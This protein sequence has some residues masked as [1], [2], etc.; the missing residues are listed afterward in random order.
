MMNTVTRMSRRDFFAK[1]GKGSLAV[2]FSLSPTAAA[3]FSGAARAA[4][5]TSELSVL[6]GIAPDNDA[7]ITI[8]FQGTVTLFSG[9]V[10]LGTGVE[11]AFTQIVA[12]ELYVSIAAVQ[13]I[14]GDTEITPDQG[15]TAGSKSVQVQGPLVRRAAATA[16][17]QLLQ[18]AATYLG[19]PTSQLVASNGSIGI[20]PSMKRATSY[21][22]LFSGQQLDI[23]TNPSAPIKDPSAYTIVSQPVPR[24]DLPAKFT[25]TFTYVSD[26]VVP[27]MLHGRVVRVNGATSKPKNATFGGYSGTSSSRAISS[28]SSRPPSGRPSWARGR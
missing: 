9:K 12:E 23:A 19:V 28:A 10:E 27:N 2:G 18:L 6:S 22:K 21:P 25:G 13:V 16:F 1:L 11:T 3:L 5:V 8:D 17:Q 26:V 14:Q 15:Y 4:T 7:W 20:G 24:V